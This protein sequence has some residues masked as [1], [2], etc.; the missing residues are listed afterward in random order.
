M[1]GLCIIFLSM[2]RRRAFAGSPYQK[3]L[4]VLWGRML[5]DN[6]RSVC[7]QSARVVP[8]A[9]IETELTMGEYAFVM[10]FFIH[11]AGKRWTPMLR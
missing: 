4:N 9:N 8:G 11:I 10:V 7:R 6:L 5:T 1:A 3:R 2:T